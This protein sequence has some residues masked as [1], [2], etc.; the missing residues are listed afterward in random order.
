MYFHTRKGSRLSTH[1]QRNGGSLFSGE[2]DSHYKTTGQ[3]KHLS[4]KIRA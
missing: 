1:R 2:T 4:L 3:H